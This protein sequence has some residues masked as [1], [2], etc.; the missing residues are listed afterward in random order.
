M[1][2]MKYLILRCLAKRGL[3]GRTILV[4]PYFANSFPGSKSK[5]E[6]FFIQAKTYLMLKGQ[7][8][9]AHRRKAL[10]PAVC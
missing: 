2:L 8:H 7:S 3:E 6:L 10:H 1:P 4:Q 9:A 5:D